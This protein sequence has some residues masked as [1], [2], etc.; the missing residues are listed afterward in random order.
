MFIERDLD[1]ERYGMDTSEWPES[2]ETYPPVPEEE[3]AAIMQKAFEAYTQKI[4][5]RPNWPFITKE[6]DEKA[7]EEWADRAN[8]ETIAELNASGVLPF[9]MAE[10]NDGWFPKNPWKLIDGCVVVRK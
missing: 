5:S 6:Y 10:V 3:F 1:Y 2:V 4:K 9:E 8:K 7:I